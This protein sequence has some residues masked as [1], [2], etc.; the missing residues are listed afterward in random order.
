MFAMY[1]H[2]KA[3]AS[4]PGAKK[5]QPL[6]PKTILDYVGHVRVQMALHGQPLCLQSTFL[7]TR[8]A[9]QLRAEPRDANWKS[10]ASVAMVRAMIMNKDL[11]LATRVAVSTVWRSTWRVGQ[12]TSLWTQQYNGDRAIL[13]RDVHFEW[14]AGK[15]VAV[16]IKCRG[17]KGDKFNTGNVKWL[18][19]AADDCL[20]PVELFCEFWDATEARGFEA[21]KPLFRH[22]NDGK[23]V[24]SR[25]VVDAIKRQAVC[26][27]LDPKHYAGH[28]LRIG[29]ATAMTAADL[30]M[31]DKM[32]QG[33]WQ[34][35]EASLCYMRRSDAM[36][37][38]VAKA[39]Q[40][41]KRLSVGELEGNG[42]D[43]RYFA[44]PRFS[45]RGSRW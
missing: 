37:Q 38:R 35:L 7:F 25:H 31:Y 23:L 24:T 16:Q 43:S 44:R 15:R 41:P 39:L 8:L 45:D 32:Q 33:G 1:L 28:S 34:S 2:D 19:A 11:S 26:M 6:A 13:R 20:C 21:D 29:G 42:C 17:S 10:P 18:T 4:E 9:A 3:W 12:A 14:V 27:G 40:L 36:E 30:S 22:V 5:E